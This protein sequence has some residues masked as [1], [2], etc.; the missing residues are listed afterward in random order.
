[1][2]AHIQINNSALADIGDTYVQGTGTLKELSQKYGIPYQTLKQYSVKLGWPARRAEAL[3]IAAAPKITIHMRDRAEQ[4]YAWKLKHIQEAPAELKS[5]RETYKRGIR[6]AEKAGDWTTVKY[7][8]EALTRTLMIQRTILGIELDERIE[9][10]KAKDGRGQSSQPLTI[11]LDETGWR[12]GAVVKG[13]IP[14]QTRDE[15]HN[16]NVGDSAEGDKG[17]PD[18]D[19]DREVRE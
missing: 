1:M 9:S 16:G 3:A 4:L 10:E 11:P 7:L 12:P 6:K 18:G 8:G 19:Q 13:Q 15:D 5:I 17:Q 2:P 14:R